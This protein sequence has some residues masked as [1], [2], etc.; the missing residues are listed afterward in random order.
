MPTMAVRARGVQ[1][2]QCRAKPDA[3]TGA[4]WV[5]YAPEAELF[6]VRGRSVGS[7]GPGP[8]WEALD[9][10]AIRGTVKARSDAPMAGAIPWLLLASKSTGKQGS[11]SAIT[12][13]Q[14]VNT[15]GGV[16]PIEG[17]DRGTLGQAVRIPYT[18]DYVFYS[19]RQQA[20]EAKYMSLIGVPPA[21]ATENSP[22]YA[23]SDL[24]KE[25]E[26]L[27]MPLPGQTTG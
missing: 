1:I 18:A 26:S 19:P 12:S 14:R 25:A 11:F 27:R 2:Y 15:V 7:H 8:V 13:V 3:A 20:A 4:E 23:G 24:S 21:P 5:F 22:T 6:D 9:G 16:A 17:C 10:S